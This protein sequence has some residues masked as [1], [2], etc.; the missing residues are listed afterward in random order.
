MPRLLTTISISEL[1]NMIATRRRDM[2]K[3]AKRRA[4]AL[5]LLKGIETAIAQISGNGTLAELP[6][7][8]RNESNLPDAL[9]QVLS[10][11]THPLGIREIADRVQ[12]SGYKSGSANFPGLVNL[13]LIKDKRFTRVS[14]GI[15][16]LWQ[17]KVTSTD[18]ENSSA[19]SSCVP[20]SR[21]KANLSTCQRR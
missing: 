5:K 17:E 13:T 10:K 14:R 21:K 12:A 4:K 3:L 2:K 8:P 19:R 11:T 9:H 1:Q 18:C 16:G 7:R 15:Y 20:C 6:R